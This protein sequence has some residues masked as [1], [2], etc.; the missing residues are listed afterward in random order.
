MDLSEFSIFQFVMLGFMLLIAGWLLFLVLTV[1]WALSIWPSDL[2]DEY[3]SKKTGK[4]IIRKGFN[5]QQA[6]IFLIA[7][8]LLS[9][10]VTFDVIGT[11]LTS[12]EK[13]AS[14]C[15][16]RSKYSYRVG[17]ICRDGWRSSSTG[18][19]TCSHHGGV[20]EWIMKEE[21]GKSEDDCMEWA[22]K[23]SWVD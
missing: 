16:E 9:G 19:G 10:P 21:Y 4:P 11:G 15:R 6:I 14:E 22:K 17:A 13:L 12:A 3:I 7:I 23:R 2:I 5:L 20:K 1:I 8:T 18:R